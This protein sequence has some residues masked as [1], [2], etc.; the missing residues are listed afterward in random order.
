MNVGD[1]TGFLEELDDDQYIGTE[2]SADD[3]SF[4]VENHDVVTT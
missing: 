1:R 4:G 2:I 3:Q